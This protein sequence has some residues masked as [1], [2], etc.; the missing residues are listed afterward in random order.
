MD[1][2]DRP[3]DSIQDY[4]ENV[5]GIDAFSGERATDEELARMAVEYARGKEQKRLG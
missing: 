4:Y 1:Y 3:E 5:A 2:G